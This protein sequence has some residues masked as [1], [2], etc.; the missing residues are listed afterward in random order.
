MK[1]RWFW[2]G[3]KD[4]EAVFT[5]SH[6]RPCSKAMFHRCDNK[7]QSFHDV[8]LNSVHYIFGSLEEAKEYVEDYKKRRN[9]IKYNGHRIVQCV[10]DYFVDVTCNVYTTKYNIVYTIYGSSLD[11]VKEMID[12]FENKRKKV[13]TRKVYHNID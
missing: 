10:D 3:L 12:K 2:H 4:S 13:K 5:D 8:S 9:V 1:K 7:L 11:E 6:P